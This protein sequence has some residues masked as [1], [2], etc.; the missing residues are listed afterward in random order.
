M[1][2]RYN[3]Y[4]GNSQGGPVDYSVRVATVDGLSW[5]TAPLPVPSRTRFGIRA[6]DDATG[7]EEQNI[8]C[9]Y[10]IIINDQ[11]VNVSE[12]PPAPIGIQVEARGTD[13][14]LV[15]W[16]YLYRPPLPDPDSF[17]LRVQ[18][19]GT[20]DFNLPGVLVAPFVNGQSQYQATIAG[21]ISGASYAVSVR[22]ALGPAEDENATVLNVQTRSAPPKNPTDLMVT[23]THKE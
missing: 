7:L 17:V 16:T 8:D 18:A 11:G 19:S 12:R 23:A 14:L 4:A 15:R 5:Q 13:G 6:W 1:V 2:V 22:S 9:V 10:E 3:I 20:M 21:L